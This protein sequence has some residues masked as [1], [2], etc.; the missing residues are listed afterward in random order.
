[1]IAH[2]DIFLLPI[3]TKKTCLILIM[4]TLYGPYLKSFFFVL[5]GKLGSKIYI[6]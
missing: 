1:M 5:E 2:F 6:F 4:Y 3:E